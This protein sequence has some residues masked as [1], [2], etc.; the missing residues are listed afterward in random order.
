M[1][2][3]NCRA[4]NPDGATVCCVCGEAFDLPA[5]APKTKKKSILIALVV[6]VSVAAAAS[7][8]AIA[9]F[10]DNN[11]IIQKIGEEIVTHIY[12]ED[13]TCD[14]CRDYDFRKVTEKVEDGF[15]K[16][17]VKVSGIEKEYSMTEDGGIYYVLS[18]DIYKTVDEESEYYDSDMEAYVGGYFIAESLRYK[19]DQ[20]SLYG[21]YSANEKETFESDLKALTDSRKECEEE[22]KEL[23][24]EYLDDENAVG[25][26]DG[27]VEYEV[28]KYIKEQYANQE[29]VEL[30]DFRSERKVS[31]HGAY[32]QLVTAK[33]LTDGEHT[34]CVFAEIC[35]VDGE[36]EYYES[37]EYL[38]EEQEDVDCLIEDWEYEFTD[39]DVVE[40]LNELISEKE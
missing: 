19:E 24:R 33:I 13:G 23:L 27:K 32:Y 34:S 11:N 1:M 17:G 15:E 12:G 39:E 14:C 10:T 36:I 40:V 16:M 7:V 30:C 35:V 26:S 20:W 25:Y 18:G 5:A 29:N 3:T 6:A 38:P 37:E 4:I 8:A 22:N 9:A 2:C 28:K 31:I 21:V